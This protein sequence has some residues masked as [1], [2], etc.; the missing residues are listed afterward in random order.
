MYGKI[1]ILAIDPVARSVTFRY[2]VN[3]NCGYLGLEPGLPRN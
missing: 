3:N 2:L 1:E